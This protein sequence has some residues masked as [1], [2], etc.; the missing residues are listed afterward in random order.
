MAWADLAI[1]VIPLGPAIAITVLSAA[2]IK[3]VVARRFRLDLGTFTI[4]AALSWPVQLLY[5]FTFEFLPHN[6]AVTLSLAVAAGL[7]MR[8]QFRRTPDEPLLVFLLTINLLL[9]VAGPLVVLALSA[10]LFGL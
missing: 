9:V 5:L 3:E 6:L 10:T 4:I 7:F 1:G 2:P 8:R